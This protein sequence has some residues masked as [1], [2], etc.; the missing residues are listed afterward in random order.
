M[1]VEAIA[2]GAIIGLAASLYLLALGQVAGI[3]GIF[4]G[5]LPG[6]A[7]EGK[8]VKLAFLAGLVSV[9]VVMKVVRPAV[10]GP[11]LPVMGRD[12]AVMA[13]AGVLV[14]FGTRTSGGCTSGHGVCGISRGSGRSIVATM[15]FMAVA[16]VVV[17]V[18]RALGWP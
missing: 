18:R 9:A 17:A 1:I 4:A 10:F 14:G 11:E 16:I 15:T 12:L 8:G 7:G 3:S 2:G 13:I 5:V 6:E